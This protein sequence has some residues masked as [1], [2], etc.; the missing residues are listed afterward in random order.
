[1]VSKQ[2]GWMGFFML[3]VV[4]LAFAF[5]TIGMNSQNAVQERGQNPQDDTELQG[6]T[7]YNEK[8]T[9]QAGWLDMMFFRILAIAIVI[10]M[11]L[12]GIGM[13]VN[14]VGRTWRRLRG[15]SRGTGT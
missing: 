2:V 5:I 13:L 3:L 6:V 8:A 11:A 10:I 1:M 4:V 7:D 14:T 9:G 15:G 12:I